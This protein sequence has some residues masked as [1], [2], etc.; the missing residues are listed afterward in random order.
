MTDRRQA[1]LIFGVSFA[2]ALAFVAGL[3]W[4]LKCAG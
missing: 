2:V 3:T 4:G 1:C